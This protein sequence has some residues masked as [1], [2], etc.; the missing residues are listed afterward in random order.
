MI[1]AIRLQDV[2][3]FCADSL[4]ARLH[5]EDVSFTKICTDTRKLAE[6]EL[7]IALKGERFDAHDFIKDAVAA[8]VCA[9]VVERFFPEFPI[10]QL[11]VSDT[12]KALGQIAAMNRLAFTGPVLAITGSSGKTTVKAMLASVL[13]EVGSVLATTGNLNNHIG[14][15]LTL[16]ELSE[17]HEFAVIEMGAS[18]PGE[19][20][21][22][23]SLAKPQIAMI[24]NVMP[25]HIE[26]FGSLEGVAHAKGEIYQYLDAED[27]AVVNRDDLLASLYADRLKAKV[28]WVS[29]TDSNADCFAEQ[30][31]LALGETEFTLNLEGQAITVRL[32]ALG[33]HNVKNAL[34]AAA[35]AYVAGASLEQIAT[36]LEK[37]SP[38][39]GRL[40]SFVGVNNARVIDDSYNANPGSVRAAI[41]V[42]AALP[43]TRTLVLGDLG[44]LG[45]DAAHLHQE[46][47]VYAKEKG[48]DQLLTLGVLSACASK[49]FGESAIHFAAR[50]SLIEFI[51]Q[52]ANKNTTYLIKGSRSAKMD[53]VVSA[54]CQSGDLH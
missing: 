28:F 36:G 48:L 32:H 35:M 41:D 42:L 18:G 53:L 6:G 33:E 43:G 45:P 27:V 23:C 5:G 13:G 38:V 30:I 1:G 26:G 14:V 40:K 44:E 22:S 51:E 11:V 50:E 2:A 17:Q 19:I 29:L 9:C 4:S 8:N 3:L 24:N 16:L 25:A 52:Q 21:Y 46:L 7:F 10:T 31:K 49:K 54:L 39:N 20:A 34:M 37:F 15:P 47:G 12:T